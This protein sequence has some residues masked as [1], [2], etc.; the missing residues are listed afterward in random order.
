MRLSVSDHEDAAARLAAAE[1]DRAQIPLLSMRFPAMDMDD[2]YAIQDTWVGAKIRS[3]DRVMGWKIGLTSQAMQS[4]LSIDTPDSGV[5]FDS[6]AFANDA[7]VPADRFIQPRIEAELAFVMKRPLEGRNLPV[8]AIL[9]A[10]HHV[11]P[12]IEIL[13]TRIVRKDA[14]TGRLRTV[15]DT[16][17]DNAANA[18]IVVG[19]PIVDFDTLDLRWI[20]A[21]VSRDGAVEETG[22]G[23][24]VLG[25]PAR[26][27]SWLV[28]RLA[29]YGA[30][31]EA[32]QTVLS[33]SFIRPIECPPGSHIRA[34][35][36]T[37]GRIE[38]RFASAD[39][40]GA[41]LT[42]GGE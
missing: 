30:R 40:A 14:E 31:I 26:S 22:L 41:D 15:L 13:D 4:A 12:A 27:V 5:L 18:G 37:F 28:D 32:G 3:G 2:A 7:V 9:E 33:G 8:E 36:G 39:E 16:I 42:Q 23:A 10:T 38:C 6:M 29:R 24:G 25:A 19:D 35:F 34:D 21:I 11:V 17:A 20:G 1:R